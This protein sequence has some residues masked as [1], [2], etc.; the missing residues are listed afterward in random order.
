MSN[1]PFSTN[2]DRDVLKEMWRKFALRA[3]NLKRANNNPA[4]IQ[5]TVLVNADGN[6]IWWTEPRVITLEPRAN[7][8]FTSLQESLTKEQMTLL[9][10]LIVGNA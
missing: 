9:L 8:D 1:S 2:Y 7:F 3:Q 5:M 6:P 4:I 10:N